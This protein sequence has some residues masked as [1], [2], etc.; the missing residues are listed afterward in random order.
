MV[1]EDGPDPVAWPGAELVDQ[2]VGRLGD[3]VA[4]GAVGQLD[5]LVPVVVVPG[6]QRLVAV[7]PDLALGG[8]VETVEC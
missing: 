4:E 3:P 2:E 1:G 6:E 8:D 7:A 5:P